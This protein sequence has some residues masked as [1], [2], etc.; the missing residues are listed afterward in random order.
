METRLKF[1]SFEPLID[2]L[3]FMVQKLRPKKQ[4]LGKNY[5]K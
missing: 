4:H 1:K 3:G 5:P 2:F